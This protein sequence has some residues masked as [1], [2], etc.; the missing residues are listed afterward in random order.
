MDVK[1]NLW[2]A[3]IKLLHIIIIVDLQFPPSWASILLL[4]MNELVD[5]FKSSYKDCL[6]QEQHFST[7]TI[8][9]ILKHASNNSQI[10][11]MSLRQNNSSFVFLFL[12]DKLTNFL[13]NLIFITI[14]RLYTRKS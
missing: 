7:F 2:I 5:S 9:K 3:A 14:K 4:L 8:L 10:R 11:H 13:L 1:A 6:E 12:C